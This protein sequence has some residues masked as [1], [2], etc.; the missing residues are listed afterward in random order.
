MLQNTGFS[1]WAML[2]SN[3]RPLPYG[4]STTISRLFGVVQNYL[5]IGIFILMA[6]RVCSS[7]FAWVAAPLLHTGG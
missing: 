7:L 5:E 3:Q 1:K 4:V 2:G 6:H